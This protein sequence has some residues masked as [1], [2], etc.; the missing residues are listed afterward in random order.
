MDRTSFYRILIVGA[1]ATVASLLV[2]HY[3]QQDDENPF[4]FVGFLTQELEESSLQEELLEEGDEDI[5]GTELIDSSGVSDE[6]EFGSGSYQTKTTLEKKEIVT[7]EPL[8]VVGEISYTESTLSVEG[9]IYHTNQERAKENISSLV[10]N[11]KLSRA[12][13]IKLNDMFDRQYFAHN[14]S[15]GGMGADDLAEIV[16]YDFILI[17]ENL[18]MGNFEDD[19]DLVDAWMDSPG[20]RLNILRERY[21]EIG[22]AVGEGRYLGKETWMAVQIFGTPTSECPAPDGEI[23]SK[24]EDNKAVLDVLYGE[25]SILEESIKENEYS[26]GREYNRAVQQYNSLVE[27]YNELI[28]E[29][30][31]LIERL[32]TQVDMFNECVRG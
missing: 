29:T 3:A 23:E 14:D 25:I 27:G 10:H 21:S 32:N 15:E 16:G 4:S 19:E 26:S 6:K 8:E 1:F 12:A 7:P 18:A 22:V 17:G 28:K 31:L 2:F 30:R 11:E 20:H 13:R 24:I 5:E 9:I